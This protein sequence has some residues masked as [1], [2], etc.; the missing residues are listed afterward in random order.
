[1]RM[2]SRVIGGVLAAT[3]L[4]QLAACGTLFFP[5]RRGQIEGKVDPL[6]VGLDAIG[7]LFYVIPGLIAFGAG[8]LLSSLIPAS[9]VEQRAAE[10]L[11][12]QAAP[13]VDEAKQAAQQLR[14]DLEP[15]AREAA[16]SVKE[17]AA[18]AASHLKEQGT[19][20]AQGLKA[21]SQD[22]ARQVKDT[23]KDA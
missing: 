15:A 3:L 2:H 16:G 22:A 6:V 7:I 8:L 4:T 13:L 21:E 14:E 20:T 19:D 11:K 9:R 17:S 5:D 18:E 23:A 1:M 12:E 10:G